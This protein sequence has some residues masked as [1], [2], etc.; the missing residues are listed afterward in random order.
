MPRKERYDVMSTSDSNRRRLPV[1]AMP[2]LVGALLI[3]GMFLT[4]QGTQAS[5]VTPIFVDDNPSCQDLGYDFEAKVDPAG[6]GTVTYTV[7]PG[8]T[9]TVTGDANDHYYSWTSTFGIDAV[10]A[11]GGP[12]ANLYVYD[13]PTESFGDT[14]LSAPINPENGMPYGMS[15]ISF[16]YDLELSVSKTATTT[17]TRTWQWTI[18]KSV[19]PATWDL[20]TGD[21]GTSRYT[22]A[23]TRTGY[24]D[25]NWAVS[26]TI[27]ITNPWH[28]PASI[29][30]VT[31]VI[32]PAIAATPSC[33]VTFPYSLAAG[34][35][36][37]CTYSSPLPDGTSR[38]NTATV[39]TTGMVG[40]GS[41][42]AN[43]TFGAPTTTVNGTINVTDTYAG[44]L[45]AFSATGSTTY[46]RTFTCDA[47]EGTHGNTATIVET[48]QSDS[49]SVD[50]DCYALTVTKDA[51]ESF[52]RT[53]DWTIDKSAD[54]TALTLS[55]GQLF[56]VNY[57]VTVDADSTDDDH[58][59]SGDISVHNPAPI[60]AT[61]N[62]VTDVV[63]P[64]IAGSVSCGVTFPYTLAA[65]GTLNCTYSADLPDATAR[66]NTATATLQN[67]AFP[68]TG[69]GVPGG[70]TSFAGT[71]AVSFVGAPFTEVDECI[72]VSDTND[73]VLGVVCASDAPKTY[74]YALTFGLH[75]DADVM[76]ECGENTHTNIASF[77]TNDTGATGQDTW[78][79]TADVECDTGCTLTPGYWKTHSTYGPAP[80][81]DTWAAIGE[82]TAFFLSGKTYYQVLW[83]PP[84]GNPYYI[85]AH[86]YIAAELNIEN[87]ASTSPTV[88][89]AMAD[90]YDFFLTANPATKLPKADRTEVLAWAWLLDAYNNGIIGPGHCSE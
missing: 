89:D 25:S 20:F 75:P 22:V 83:T 12:N 21:S 71:A 13:P 8:L 68:Y 59:V 79:V 35:T 10:I 24:V 64:A 85:L 36:L 48:G 87:G 34:G 1:V 61:I 33:G 38:V 50:V 26:G 57:E 76:L 70:T 65:G 17:F 31:D 67:Y 88:D 46:N 14:G 55:P 77:V 29:T 74:T 5:S 37:N 7:A 62:S 82:N 51:D 11:K 60:P 4:M 18:D 69:A 54:Q 49:A 72:T 81:D 47:D 40:G 53:W 2:A 32:S 27:T 86:A 80:Y 15:H 45:G 41:A 39:T 42:T 6:P 19:T 23:V 16:C 58:A 56:P 30:A 73:G 44:S 3:T 28:V 90:A 52:V 63:S 43:V 78:T 66:T 84:M 9:I